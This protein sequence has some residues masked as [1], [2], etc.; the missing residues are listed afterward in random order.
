MRTTT[1]LMR[2]RRARWVAPSHS[3]VKTPHR[4]TG[5][6][7]TN[8]MI[9]DP[10]EAAGG[11]YI[12][13]YVWSTRESLA[14]QLAQRITASWIPA[15]ERRLSFQICRSRFHG[16]LN[17][18]LQRGAPSFGCTTP[19]T[20]RTPFGR[21]AQ[22]TT[23]AYFPTAP[24][25]EETLPLAGQLSAKGTDNGLVVEMQSLTRRKSPL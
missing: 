14:E 4:L 15:R 12:A 19:P 21:S 5:I 8:I 18:H 10:T 13:H 3:P 1:P 9:D 24:P 2:N 23:R 17:H 22:R 20:S 7:I 16:L 6:T 25:S 11:T